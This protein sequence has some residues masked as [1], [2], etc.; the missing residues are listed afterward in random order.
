MGVMWDYNNFVRDLQ[1]GCTIVEALEA[2]TLHPALLLNIDDRKGTLDFGTDA[3]FV[4]LHP[5]NLEV[6]ST[7]IAGEC[8]YE[9]AA[10]NCLTFTIQ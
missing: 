4:I 3:D 10:P 1:T 9:K 6:Q 8:V 2:A 7:W 5:D